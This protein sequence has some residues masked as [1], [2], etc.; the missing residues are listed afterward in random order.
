MVR[1]PFPGPF[2]L[3]ETPA[4]IPEPAP[5]RSAF[6]AWRWGAALIALCL[7]VA[8]AAVLLRDHPRHA[9]LP[10]HRA[11]PSGFDRGAAGATLVDRLDR[12]L[13]SGRGLGALADPTNASAR[14]ELTSVAA[15]LH[16]LRVTHFGLRYLDVAGSAAPSSV[17]PSDHPWVAVGQLTWR[18]QGV[19]RSDSQVEVPLV[20]GRRGSRAV[21]ET[22]R[23]TDDRRVPVWFTAPVAV[24]RSAD[25]L[26]L[27]A[28]KQ[29]ASQLF[30]QAQVAVQTVRATLPRWHQPLVVEEPASGRGFETAAG[31]SATDARAIA[32]VTTTTDGSD[33][34]TSAVHVYV[35][36]RVYNPL[37]PNGQQI[38]LSHEATHVALG[39]AT[40]SL[41]MWLSEGIA[42]YVALRH[43]AVPVPTLASQIRELVR[44][45]GAPKRLPGPAQFSGANPD[46]GAYYEAA[47]VAVRLLAQEHG[48]PTLLRFYRTSDR[49]GGTQRTFRTV[50]GTTQAQFT[51][52]WQSYLTSL[53]R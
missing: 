16:K 28:R 42:D 51:R 12:A 13:R 49:L 38:V 45:H 5:R 30:R 26:V 20:L 47:W 8:G 32:A 36:P 6:S 27:S 46:I 1:C 52:R 15:N 17:P 41:P 14:R 18:L 40:T 2:A 50:L 43:S 10:T 4:P 35:N 7:V 39:A 34:P 9:V 53:A 25:A 21:F 22:A 29:R 33:L 19:D 48:E 11:S 37:G 24:R 31:M 23:F 3:A 44:K